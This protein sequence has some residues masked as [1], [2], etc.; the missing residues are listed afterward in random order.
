MPE[1]T[2]WIFHQAFI[3]DMKEYRLQN[4]NGATKIQPKERYPMWHASPLEQKQN[5]IFLT[6]GSKKEKSL[7]A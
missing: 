1:L 4:K 2:G 3:A 6:R 5:K 7:Q